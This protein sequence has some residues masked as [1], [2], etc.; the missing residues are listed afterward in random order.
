MLSN[1][2]IGYYILKVL[3]LS[4]IPA[5]L[6]ENNPQASFNSITLLVFNIEKRYKNLTAS[7][8]THYNSKKLPIV[9]Y[10]FINGIEKSNKTVLLNNFNAFLWCKY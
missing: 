5:I 6:F 1:R 4:P 3:T 10:C 9:I 7:L 8:V 2:V